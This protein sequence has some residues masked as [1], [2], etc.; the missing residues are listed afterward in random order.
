MIAAMCL[1][2]LLTA[3]RTVGAEQAVIG[4]IDSAGTRSIVVRADPAAGLDSS[5]LDR[6]ANLEGVE[7]SG[8]FGYAEDV[9]NAAFPGG[10]RVPLRLAYGTGWAE[11][12]LPD[13]LPGAGD[14]AFAS[15]AA[16]EQLGMTDAVGRIDGGGSG[17]AIGRRVA[18]P[19]HL[20]FLEPVLIAPQPGNPAEPVG[21]VV[22]T[23][24]RPDLVAP[25][26]SAVTGV[27]GV[28]DA[29]K[30]TVET[31]EDLATLRALVEGQLGQFGRALTLGILVLTAL[32]TTAIL[33]G[34]VMMRRKDFGRRRAL[35]ASRSLII[36]LLLTQTGLLA[37]LGASVGSIAAL[38][39]L[40][41]T[42]DP[43]PGAAYTCAIAV[44]AVVVAV[45][46]ALL[47]ATAAS[48]R[49]PIAEL[50]VP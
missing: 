8:A 49:E 46:A 15:A 29:T 34:L 9:Q 24:A 10:N 38:I 48:R 2:V 39:V 17:F 22:V 33:Y 44:L 32:L 5:V 13:E 23:A 11:L 12:S 1:A 3:G 18:V 16:L 4:S 30:V 19:D 42:G 40:G 7:W 20:R 43:L 21:I 27:L 41:A 31:S 36:A 25:V 28:A 47:P 14:V 45:A 50:R 26:A 37:L 6:I 35:G